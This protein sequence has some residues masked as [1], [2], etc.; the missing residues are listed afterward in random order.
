MAR[1]TVHPFKG[2]GPVVFSVFTKLCGTSLALNLDHFHHPPPYLTR[3]IAPEWSLPPF[4]QLKQ[5]PVHFPSMALT[6]REVPGKGTCIG[7]PVNTRESFPLAMVNNALLIFPH[8]PLCA[9]LFS[10]QP[11]HFLLGLLSRRLTLLVP[12]CF[13]KWSL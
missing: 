3:K 2:H 6:I 8:R 4:P 1:Y 9:Q 11:K 5:L 13:P 12:I 10:S 7:D